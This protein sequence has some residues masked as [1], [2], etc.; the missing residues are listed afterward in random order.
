MLPEKQIKGNDS[1]GLA[2]VLEWGD[3]GRRCTTKEWRPLLHL[4]KIFYQ[5]S[6]SPLTSPSPPQTRIIINLH[7]HPR[8]STLTTHR[9]LGQQLLLSELSQFYCINSKK[10]FPILQLSHLLQTLHQVPQVLYKPEKNSIRM[11]PTSEAL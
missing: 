5:K 7:L 6:G 8:P 11:V 2:K 1:A 3:H 9:V 4:H 10:I